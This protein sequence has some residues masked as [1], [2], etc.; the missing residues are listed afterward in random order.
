MAEL[1]GVA[2]GI[3]DVAFRIVLYLKDVKA[4]T[5]TIDG[6]IAALIEQVEALRDVH[7]E[8]ESEMKRSLQDDTMQGKERQLWFRVKEILQDGRTLTDE[9][10]ACVKSIYGNNPRVTG[11][12][13][14]LRKQHRKRGR[15]SRLLVHRDRVSSYQQSLQQWLMFISR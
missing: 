3:A 5:E 1:V 11:S 7:G 10:E 6:D 9:L 4:A 13:D 15:E 8:L 2:V 12:R 14:A